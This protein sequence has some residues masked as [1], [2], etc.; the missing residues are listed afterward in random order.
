MTV[1]NET[2]RWQPLATRD[3]EQG[4]AARGA[5]YARLKAMGIEPD[6]S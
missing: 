1:V 6:A 3:E 2:G 4:L 5:T